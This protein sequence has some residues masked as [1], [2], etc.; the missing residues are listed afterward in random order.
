MP[1]VRSDDG[2]SIS[3]DRIGGDGPVLVL[4]GGGLDGGTENQPLGDHVADTF[5]VVNYQRRGRGDSED[6][7]PY[8]VEREIEDL[9][10]LIDAVGGRAHL[11]G[12]SSGGALALEAA[13]AGL[14]VDRVAVHE[15]PYQTDDTMISA[16]HA[17]RL[18]LDSAL[19]AD[20]R[21][22]AL[23]LFMRL[24]GS[25][26]HDIAGAEASPVWP[27]LLELAPTLRYDAACLGEGPPPV[28][29]LAQVRQPVLLTTGVT[30]D[31]H[32]AGLPVDFFGTAADAAAA[33]LPDARRATLEVEG[34]VADPA[35]LGPLLRAFFAG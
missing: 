5:D 29:R 7:Q 32:L 9:A 26:E 1:H 10:A 18:E 21:G 34:H 20:D 8:A 17:Y 30:I 3:Y 28:E 16:W 22:Q 2:T 35:A 13:A 15:V 25:S 6:V 4:I 23:K 19:D 14:P 24:A 12:A 31:P 11:F 33:A 27:S